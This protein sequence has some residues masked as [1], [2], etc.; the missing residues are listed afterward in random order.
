MQQS[1]QRHQNYTMRGKNVQCMHTDDK[2]KE[3]A[4]EPEHRLARPWA[5]IEGGT[6]FRREV[7]QESSDVAHGRLHGA[8]T[9]ARTRSDQTMAVSC[10][11]L[12]NAYLLSCRHFKDPDVCGR[13]RVFS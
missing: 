5:V 10:V 6:L 3:R 1:P 8:C 13:A 9:C 7:A 12:S 4:Q 11:C 2:K